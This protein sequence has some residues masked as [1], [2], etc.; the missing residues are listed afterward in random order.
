MYEIYCKLRDLRGLKDSDVARE[1]GI[2]PVI[3][4]S[5]NPLISLETLIL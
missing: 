1:T 5:K 3:G 2:E 4:D